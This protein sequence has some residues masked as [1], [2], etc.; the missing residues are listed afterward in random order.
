MTSTVVKQLLMEE[1]DELL[2]FIPND[3]IVDILKRLP[4]KS[5][6]RFRC[7]CKD[8]NDLF[9][10]SSFIKQH[11]HH[12]THHRGPSLLLQSYYSASHHT[13]TRHTLL[14]SNKKTLMPLNVPINRSCYLSIIGVSHGIVCLKFEG[15]LLL[16]NPAT[17]ETQH[18]PKISINYFEYGVISYSVETGFGF[19]TVL[20]DYKIVIV[21]AFRPAGNRAHVYSLSTGSWKEVE[22]GNVSVGGIHY[23]RT[24]ATDEAI[25]WLAI[26]PMGGLLILS[27]HTAKEVFTLI[28][29]PA[30]GFFQDRNLIV[31]E[32]NLA[33]LNIIELCVPEEATSGEFEF[34]Q[35]WNS[36]KFIGCLGSDT[37]LKAMTIWRNE[38]VFEPRRT[39][40]RGA[41]YL[42]NLTTNKLK[43]FPIDSFGDVTAAFNY[44]ESLVSLGMKQNIQN[45]ILNLK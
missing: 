2:F 18:V 32:N 29:E 21:Y 35:R 33:L 37:L 31:H 4:V 26:N 34:G 30:S 36:T 28:P 19:N 13:I 38:V 42:F 9:K 20:N 44:E 7:V 25:Y 12:S 43:L 1:E 5:L 14:D 27:F 16:W 24:T 11:F 10:T 15:S 22:F 23:R 41:I 40:Y 8:W 39:K 3:I 45:M 6:L 17:R